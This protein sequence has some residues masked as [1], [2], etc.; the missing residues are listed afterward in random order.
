MLQTAF[1][2]QECAETARGFSTFDLTLSSVD[3]RLISIVDLGV[4]L[5]R[6]QAVDVL[7]KLMA[8]PA[9]VVALPPV[10]AH[11]LRYRPTA[12]SPYRPTQFHLSSYTIPAIVLR[13]PRYRPLPYALA[14]RCAVPALFLALCRTA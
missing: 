9:P 4:Y 6:Y 8:A 7:A 14:G 11:P 12:A 5:V 2:P 13:N 1:L 10:R 3:V